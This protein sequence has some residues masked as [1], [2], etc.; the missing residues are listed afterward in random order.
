MVGDGAGGG[1]TKDR[2]TVATTT[3]PSLPFLPPP[4][5]PFPPL[6]FA[7]LRSPPLPSAFPPSLRS[8]PHASPSV[9]G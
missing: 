6:P 9:T 4:S 5:L 2:G 1:V 3:S 7:S 8:P